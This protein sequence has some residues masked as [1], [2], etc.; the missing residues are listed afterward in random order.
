MH[1]KIQ[2][3]KH[4]LHPTSVMAIT[5]PQFPARS[6]MLVLPEPSTASSL[7]S[8]L[9]S[10]RTTISVTP[11]RKSFAEFQIW[12]RW[13]KTFTTYSTLLLVIVF[14]I[15]KSICGTLL[16]KRSVSMNALFT[17]TTRIWILIRTEIVCG[18]STSSST[19]RKWKESSFSAAKLIRTVIQRPTMMICITVEPR[20]E[21]VILSIDARWCS[22]PFK[23]TLYTTKML[24]ST[25]HRL[26]SFCVIS[27]PK[28][29]KT[30]KM[31]CETADCDFQPPES[32]L[33]TIYLF[34]CKLLY[35]N[36]L[37]LSIIIMIFKSTARAIR[38]YN[39]STEIY[40]ILDLVYSQLNLT[41]SLWN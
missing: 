3:Y 36:I 40:D 32:Y 18:T 2:V 28:M 35:Q 1:R 24:L 33:S 38:L 6:R 8:T 12:T 34:M 23:V 9:V 13:L 27:L 26:F 30:L 17:V 15:S 25:E 14:V 29:K 20:W 7:P 39:L 22:D 16:I 41:F 5:A 4:C 11:S 37:L 10:A 19:T 31:C 21:A